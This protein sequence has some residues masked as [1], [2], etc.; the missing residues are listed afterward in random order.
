[1]DPVVTQLLTGL[2]PAGAVAVVMYAWL[3]SVRNENKELK[4]EL[5]G[6]RKEAIQTMER[7]LPLVTSVSE[8]V[9]ANKREAERAT[10]DR[11]DAVL[12]G[13]EAQT[14]KR[15]GLDG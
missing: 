5:A 14:S 4:A 9:D 7:V 1:M 8:V 10:H 12:R 6:A 3:Q 15:R 2:G 11:L 13:L